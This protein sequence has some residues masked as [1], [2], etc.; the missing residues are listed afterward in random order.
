MTRKNLILNEYKQS[1]T[2]SPANECRLM[3]YNRALMPPNEENSLRNEP[4]SANVCAA[5]ICGVVWLS[6][7]RL[8]VLLDIRAVRNEPSPQLSLSLC[9]QLIVLGRGRKKVLILEV[10]LLASVYFREGAASF[11]RKKNSALPRELAGG[12]R[13]VRK[14][15][16]KT[17]FHFQFMFFHL[18]SSLPCA[19][20]L[21]SDI[22]LYF[23]ARQR[24]F[25]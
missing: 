4:I 15:E 6:E 13:L 17:R 21:V 8:W 3:L 16:M 22:D 10:R 5:N 1:S 2:N 24:K 18:V 12:A 23:S 9:L 25:L 14:S 11:C 19:P 7:N 20:A